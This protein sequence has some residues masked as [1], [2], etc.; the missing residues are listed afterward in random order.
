MN[1]VLLSAVILLTSLVGRWGALGVDV[2]TSDRE[3]ITQAIALHAYTWDARDLEAWSELFAED[4]VTHVYPAGGD[5]PSW[6]SRSREELLEAGR[7]Y[8]ANT[9]KD[10]QSRHHLSSILFLESNGDAV[11]T[12]CT[13]LVTHRSDSEPAPHIVSSGIYVMHWKRVDGQ[14]RITRRDFYPD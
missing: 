5:E 11:K 13:V 10:T 14:W 12:R 3:K 9:L 4:A 6:T 1:R 7:N 2:T 8:Q